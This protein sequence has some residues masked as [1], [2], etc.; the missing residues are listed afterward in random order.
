MKA[1]VIENMA[2]DTSTSISTNSGDLAAF[3]IPRT[4]AKY[5]ANE[6]MKKK[7]PG[8]KSGMTIRSRAKLTV[9]EVA[10]IVR[11]IQARELEVPDC[12]YTVGELAKRYNTT[13]QTLRSKPPIRTA[14][15][16]ARATAKAALRESEDGEST[17]EDG[18][19]GECP[20]G[21]LAS[22]NKLLKKQVAE[23]YRIHQKLTLALANR[24][25]SMD[26][27]MSEARCLDGGDESAGSGEKNPDNDFGLRVLPISRV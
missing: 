9:P 12:P 25:L 11:D 21:D 14:L 16:N 24:G 27:L 17:T 5:P 10:M 20:S 2:F 23:F 7:R 19:A 3:G 13:G 6:E 8:L 4:A 26:Q 18:A 1:S 15:E 22:E